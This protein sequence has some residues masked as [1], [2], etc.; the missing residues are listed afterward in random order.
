MTYFIIAFIAAVLILAL[1]TRKKLKTAP[2]G[3]EDARGFHTT[4]TGVR[5]IQCGGILKPGKE[6]FAGG[7]CDYCKFTP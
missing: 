2:R 5:C 7:L 4:G 3:Y 6:P 1:W